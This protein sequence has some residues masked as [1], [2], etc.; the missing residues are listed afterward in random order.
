MSR[1]FLGVGS[2]TFSFACGTN[3]RII[4]PHPMNAFDLADRAA[5]LGLS[6][7]QIADN[8]PLNKLTEE[9]LILL[10]KRCRERGVRLE[11]GFRGMEPAQ[12]AEAIE[13]T[14][15]TGSHLMRCVIDRPGFQP[16]VAEIK[17]IIR[18]VLPR[19][20]ELDITLGIENHDRFY[21]SEYLE[22]IEAANDPH[23]GMILDTVNSL[24]NEES[25]DSVLDNLARYAVSFHAKDY[26]IKRRS[27]E[28]GFVITGACAGTGHLDIPGIMTRIRKETNRD[29][30]VILESWMESLPGTEETIRQ[31]YEWAISGLAYL[32][33][34][35]QMPE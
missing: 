29:L 6:V 35:L 2:Y 15:I 13:I 18:N 30:S 27:G 19:L 5:D 3:A 21:S 33:K 31:E 10:N 11:T 7:V 28:M 20:K 9:E 17:Q 12:L 4:P 25:I 32:R 1:I 24:A 23:V 22:I 14:R 26:T 16:T 34:C 8:V